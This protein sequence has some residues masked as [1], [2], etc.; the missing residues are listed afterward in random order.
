MSMRASWVPLVWTASSAD[1]EL[2][3]EAEEGVE[4]EGPEAELIKEEAEEG[5][6][7]K[8]GAAI[9]GWDGEL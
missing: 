5:E 3:V 2:E 7:E 4:R 6:E 1:A 9:V 8:V